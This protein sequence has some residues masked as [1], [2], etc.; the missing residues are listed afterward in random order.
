MCGGCSHPAYT[1]PMAAATR[2]QSFHLIRWNH[3]KSNF[4]IFLSLHKMSICRSN[5]GNFDQ[6]FV[7]QIS[8]ING[9]TYLQG[10]RE[11]IGFEVS[12]RIII[13]DMPLS[14][15][16]EVLLLVSS[17]LLLQSVKSKS[18]I[19]PPI[20]PPHQSWCVFHRI[21]CSMHNL[22]YNAKF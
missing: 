5:F 17:E 6:R 11:I 2:V 22:V 1:H 15:K 16:E 10:F 9:S 8:A 18:S 19:F 7:M 14:L 21:G 12:L 20:C 3:I 4:K 13:W